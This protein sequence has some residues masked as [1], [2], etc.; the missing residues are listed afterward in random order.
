MSALALLV[1]RRALLDYARRPLNLVLLLAVPVVLVFVWG[2]TLADFSNLVGGTAD[3]V[4]VEAATAGWAAAALA[5]LGGFFQVSGSRA[6]DRRLAAARG[7]AG[8]VVAGRLGAS[9]VLAV[10]ASAGGLVAL[11]VRTGINDPL[12][13]VAG[14]LL[15]ALVYLALGILVGSAVRSDMNGALVIT[16]AWILDVF[17]GPGLS[18]GPSVVTRVFPLHFPTLLLTSQ[19]TGHGGPLGDLGWSAAWAVGLSFV[20][21]M[22]LVAMTRPVAA[23]ARVAPSSSGAAFAAVPAL[24]PPAKVARC[25]SPG[26]ARQA[27]S[28]DRRPLVPGATRTPFGAVLR[29]GMRDYRRNRVLWA[30]LVGVPAVFI[31]LAIIVTVDKPGPVD[32]VDGTTT[33]TALLSQRRIHA[34]TMVPVTAAFLA[35]LTGLFVVTGT[36][37]GDRRLVLAGFKPRQVLGG[38]LGIIGGAT[39]VATGAA[40]AVSGAWYPPR[41]WVLFA[42][43]NL[44]IAATYAMV[45]VLVGP[46]TGRLG[47]L[48]L[49][50]LLAFI[51]VGLGQTVMFPGGP[52]QLW[53]FGVARR[54][55]GLNPRHLPGRGHPSRQPLGAGAD[56]PGSAEVVTRQAEQQRR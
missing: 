55:V 13:A 53:L 19:V 22:R 12:R 11:A 37:G 34:A 27:A 21:V 45:G 31:G 48:Y 18:G 26:P 33:F 30:L 47:G 40:V 7:H 54:L 6:A 28:V 51:D 1:A 52:A 42:A 15:V 2:G 49:M 14:T 23:A 16:L 10:M 39:V 36:A 46:L 25:V 43:A 38:R 32:L 9:V 29:A 8:P 4:Q 35:G 44:L 5:G 50:L 3:P 20:A 56:D 24:V 41:Q 17:L